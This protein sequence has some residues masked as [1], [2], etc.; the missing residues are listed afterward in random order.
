MT[1][2]KI[3]ALPAATLPL[4]G[5]E[6]IPVV[7]GGVTSRAPSSSLLT[8]L[9][10]PGPIGGTT[11]GTVSAT[12]VTV[13]TTLNA[14]TA[15]TLVATPTLPGQAATKAYVDAVPVVNLASPGPIGGTTPS[16]VTATILAVTAYT[17]T[18]YAPAAGSAFTVSLNN[19]TV[20]KFTTNANTTI[21][22][23]AAAVGKSYL[24]MVAYGGVHTLTWAGG[25]AIK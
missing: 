18:L 13:A 2:I 12:T 23:P 21:T 8:N 6:D 9:A 7:Q 15:S 4:S 3:S 11:P 19:G 16:T 25:T 24:I 20:Q 17:E 5:A 22:L 1:T 14:T 10:S